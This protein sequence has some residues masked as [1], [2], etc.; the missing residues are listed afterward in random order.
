MKNNQKH[1]IYL[2]GRQLIEKQKNSFHIQRK[3][4]WSGTLGFVLHIW[5]RWIQRN[6]YIHSRNTAP[7]ASRLFLCISVFSLSLVV[8]R[9]WFSCLKQIDEH[10]NSEQW[11]QCTMGL[12]ESIS[13]RNCFTRLFCKP[14]CT[15]MVEVLLLSCHFSPCKFWSFLFDANK[16]MRCENINLLSTFFT[17]SR[18][19]W[20]NICKRVLWIFIFIPEAIFAITWKLFL[21]SCD[22]ATHSL[23]MKKF[24]AQKKSCFVLF[25]S[26]AI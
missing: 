17:H 24:I 20:E 2:N 6:I 23:D 15:R 26:V 7:T 13:R 25:L 18:L 12:R 4:I 1:E 19:Y 22:C 3:I 11:P 8:H 21:M 9:M 14:R 16:T 5:A 10:D